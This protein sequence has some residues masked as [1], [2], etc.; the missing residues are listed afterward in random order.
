VEFYEDQQL[1]TNFASLVAG[2]VGMAGIMAG[3]W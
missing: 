1:A 2:L 3:R